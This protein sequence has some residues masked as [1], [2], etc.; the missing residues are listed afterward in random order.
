MTDFPE[1]SGNAT[2]EG[3]L[4]GRAE[5]LRMI[6]DDED[7]LAE[8]AALARTEIVRQLEALKSALA[9]GD[10]AAARREAHTIKGT[11]ATLGA[12]TV[13]DVAMAAEHAA[14]DSDLAGAKDHAT[15]LETLTTRLVAELTD[16]LE[17]PGSLSGLGGR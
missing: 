16:Y 12:N 1:R 4:F 15:R 11:V 2:P 5:A 10:A 9:I 8:V 13:R 6:G 3:P 17:S 14:R 7:L